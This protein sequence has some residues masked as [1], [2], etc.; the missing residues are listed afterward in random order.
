[1]TASADAGAL[2]VSR[3]VSC[4]AWLSPCPLQPA[5]GAQLR[6]QGSSAC[7]GWLPSSQHPARFVSIWLLAAACE[8]QFKN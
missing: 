8:T 2:R 3:G 4:G 1:M 5:Q 6:P 7:W